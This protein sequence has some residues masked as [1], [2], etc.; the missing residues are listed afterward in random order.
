MFRSLRRCLLSLHRALLFHGCHKKFH[1]LGFLD[2]GSSEKVLMSTAELPP[3]NSDHRGLLPFLTPTP[4]R[5][6]PTAFFEYK[7]RPI[8]NFLKGCRNNIEKSRRTTIG[9]KKFRNDVQKV[10]LLHSK[11][12]LIT[13]KKFHSNAPLPAMSR[14][15]PSSHPFRSRSSPSST[16]RSCAPA[17]APAPA[18]SPAPADPYSTSGYTH[19]LPLP[20]SPTSLLSFFQS[21]CR[22]ILGGIPKFSFLL[23]SFFSFSRLFCCFLTTKEAGKRKKRRREEMKGKKMQMRKKKR[24][25]KAIFII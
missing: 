3:S 17:P 6:S 10:L 2:G 18:P 15:R 4:F 21:L 5:F 11:S 23:S 24:K 9:F 12:F 14:S 19:P 16:S 20:F 7:W 22:P 13:F 25:R 8:T 1:F